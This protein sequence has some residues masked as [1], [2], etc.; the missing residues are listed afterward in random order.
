MVIKDL[1][2]RLQIIRT[3]SFIIIIV[4]VKHKIK[5][6][7]MLDITTCMCLIDAWMVDFSLYI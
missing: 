7:S 4:V 6:D 5:K 2:N 1:C 3:F